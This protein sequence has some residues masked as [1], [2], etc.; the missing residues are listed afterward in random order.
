MRKKVSERLGGVVKT[1]SAAAGDLFANSET[2]GR[3]NG[4]AEELNKVQRGK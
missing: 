2:N 1:Q 3:L 4:T